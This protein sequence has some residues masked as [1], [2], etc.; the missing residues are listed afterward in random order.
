MNREREEQPALPPT[1]AA[2]PSRA[3]HRSALPPRSEHARLWLL[4]AGVVFLNHG[5][6]GACPR[7][8]LEA[9]RALRD[10]MERGPVEFLARRLDAMLDA[11]RS[12]L[13]DFVG[14]DAEGLACVRNA[15]SGVNA[16]M[17]SLQLSPGDEVI[18]TD[19]EYNACA[20]AARYALERA[21]GRVVTAHVP[22]PVR[23]PGD[24]TER[25]LACVT[26]RTR[27]AL[28][29]HVTS[30]TGLV[31]PIGEIVGALR[32]RGV[33]TLVDGAHAPGMVDVSI[34]ALAP[35]YY[36][37]NCHKWLC[38][39][40]GAGFLWARADRREGLHPTSI[41]H[42]LNMVPAGR[43][44]FR[45]EF[46]W[47]GTDDPTPFLC[48]PDALRFM[49]ALLPGGWPALRARN[50]QM[51]ARARGVLNRALGAKPIAPESMLGSM[52]SVRL[53]D[54]PGEAPAAAGHNYTDP[55]QTRL[56][57]SFGIEA[58][59][60]HFPKAPGRLLRVSAQAYNADAEYEY[61]AR[62]L[63][64]SLGRAGG[65]GPR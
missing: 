17:R 9:Q 46:D 21:G 55:L 39:P 42:G 52:A 6:F 2:V 63:V 37:A 48:V 60:V 14:A 15:T 41:S 5:S 43:S 19:H 30:Q 4:D 26:P 7:V 49:G 33:E 28:V 38:A 16:V 23:S 59:V 53:P 58:P 65:A 1:A 34:D 24:F 10:R 50:H 36:T 22:L 3:E 27:L 57:D 47:T 51:A 20:N 12:E 45:A 61:L 54:L 44:R 62:A 35:A 31:L 56:F 25:I 13:A 18:V 32:E 64:E 8:V 11:A 29:D 40:K